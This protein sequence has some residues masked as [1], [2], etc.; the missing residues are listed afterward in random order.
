MIRK[1]LFSVSLAGLI[2]LGVSPRAHSLSLQSQSGQQS[3]QAKS[4]SGKVTAIGDS[5]HSFS[6]E[7]NE[8]GSKH[9]MEF[10]V[11]KNTQ[12]QGRVT[13]GATATVEYQPS[14]GGQNVAL[15]ITVQN[16]Q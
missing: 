2:L 15:S 7:V 8:G 16:S 14:E 1:L 9:T 6:M 3:E 12:I 11:D 13:V 4:V 5:G 10:V